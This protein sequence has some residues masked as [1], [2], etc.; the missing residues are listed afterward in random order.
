MFGVF[1]DHGDGG[2]ASDYV[3]KNLRVKLTSQPE[4]TS[5]YRM[6]DPDL[7]A[8]SISSAC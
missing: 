5:A 3:A 6:R 8:S 7:L 1:D 2:H 4:W